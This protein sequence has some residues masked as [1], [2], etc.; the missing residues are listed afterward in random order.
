[1]ATL[2]A[3]LLLALAATLLA[4]AAIGASMLAEQSEIAT[5]RYEIIRTAGRKPSVGGAL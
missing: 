4:R 5:S 2:T 1:M 3:S